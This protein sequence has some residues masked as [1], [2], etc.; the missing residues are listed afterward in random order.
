MPF[1]KINTDEFKIKRFSTLTSLHDWSLPY[2]A[3]AKVRFS[4][5]L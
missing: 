5:N 1:A 4:E 2:N 3:D